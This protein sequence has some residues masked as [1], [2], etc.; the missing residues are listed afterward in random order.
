[1]HDPSVVPNVQEYGHAIP[2]GQK[3][4]ATITKRSYDL[5]FE[6]WGQCNENPIKL[7]YFRNYTMDG[8]LTGLF[9][10]VL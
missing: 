1:M 2:P 3:A 5:M 4:F 10:I 9:S 7:K 8:C 6:P